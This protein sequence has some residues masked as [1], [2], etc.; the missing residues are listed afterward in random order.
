M[1]F[2]LGADGATE[3]GALRR[4]DGPTWQGFAGG[5]EEGE[6][7]AD[8]A[9]R[10][11]TEEGGLPAGTALYRLDSR[12]SVPRCHFRAAE[13]WSPDVFVVV[14]HAFAIDCSGVPLTLSDEHEELLWADFDTIHETLRWSSNR[15]ALWELAERMRCDRLK[16]RRVDD[17]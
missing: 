3:F 11:A 2:R 14:E 16:E 6:S 12:T 4:A 17:D 15:T 9:R 7:P 5:G 1:P 13:T 10:E 8:A